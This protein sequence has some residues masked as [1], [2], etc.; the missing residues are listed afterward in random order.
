M[1]MRIFLGCIFIFSLASA[2]FPGR[3]VT[4]TYNPA[5][6]RI[7]RRYPISPHYYENYLR[8]LN[9][10]NIT[11]QNQ[12]IL[13][14]FDDD[15]GMDSNNSFPE[16]HFRLIMTPGGLIAIPILRTDDLSPINPLDGPSDDDDQDPLSLPR[17]SAETYNEYAK[18][19]NLKS[20]N[21]E[22]LV[23][24]PTRF[25]DVGGYDNIKTE[26]EQ[27]VDLLSNYTK[28]SKYNVRVPRGLIFEGPP[29]NG[30]TLI[31]K[32]LAGEAG[33]GFIAVSGS[34]FQEKYVGVGATRVRE[35]FELAKKNIPCIIFIDEIDALGRKRSGDGETSGSERDSTLNELLVALDGFKNSSGVFLIGATNRAD[36]LDAALTRPGRIDKRIY[37]GNPDTK[38]REAILRIHI[39]G[40]PYCAKIALVDLV[41]MT[42]GLSGAQIENLVNEAMLNALRANREVFDE[43]DLETALARMMVGWQPSEHQFTSDLIDH[44][45]IHEMGHV[46]TGMVAKNHA[47]V[48]KVVINLS[49]P[50]SPAYTVF[51]SN[52]SPIYKREG[53]F[54]H[55]VI[56]LAGRVAEEVCY[57]I[58]VTTGAINDFQEALTLAEKMITYYGMGKNTIYPS[59][60]EKYKQMIDDEVAELIKD[61]YTV[62][63]VIIRKHIT[64][65]KEGANILKRDRVIRAPELAKLLESNRI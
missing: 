58:S 49:A 52:T 3:H 48:S 38:T 62:A 18:K 21:F 22:V 51:E 11:I 53:L 33:V 47:K 41:E 40:K 54:E 13:G 65:V 46:V 36:L 12:S 56:L 32:A 43:T 63:D 28:Y 30:K 29:G 44:I 50:N 25:S 5:M 35:L 23:D 27:C 17:K 61:A 19:R 4:M 14:D 39:R 9:S 34:Q 20:K 64:F 59:T 6:S 60:S 31:A 10:K 45:A 16:N 8:R 42:A 15:S 55:L 37:I 57:N 7:T 2:F 24:F 1:K 26:L